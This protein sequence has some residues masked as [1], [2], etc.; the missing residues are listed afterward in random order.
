MEDRGTVT[1]RLVMT[2]IAPVRDRI[3]PARIAGAAGR[4]RVAPSRAPIVVMNAQVPAAARPMVAR[5]EVIG[6]GPRTI[7]RAPVTARRTGAIDPNPEIGR[8]GRDTRQIVRAAGTAPIIGV[9]VRTGV[10][11]P[12]KDRIEPARATDLVIGVTARIRTGRSTARTVQ[13][14]VIA[15][16]TGVIDPSA[17][18]GPSGGIGPIGRSTHRIVRV[19]GTVPVIGVTVRTGATGPHRDRTEPPRATDLVT[20]VTVPIARTGRRTD[21]TAHGAGA[22]R[23][24]GVTVRTA[25]TAR[26]VPIVRSPAPTARSVGN[27]TT[28]R[29]SDPA[30]RAGCPATCRTASRHPRPE[31][32]RTGTPATGR[33]SDRTAITVARDIETRGLGHRAA[34][35]RTAQA[36][37]ESRPAGVRIGRPARI[38][39]TG[40]TTVTRTP[41]SGVNPSADPGSATRTSTSLG[42]R[43]RSGL[44]RPIWNRTSAVTFVD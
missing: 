36:V 2:G 11:G 17:G 7:A 1:G 9:T 35:P 41:G 38:G 31:T 3:P 15:P 24:I 16:S 14:V 22:V 6:R 34:A 4:S 27:A 8:I 29:T 19:A 44:R 40:R 12:G 10:T 20:G 33:A 39:R 32:A 43:C 37:A 23:S 26:E 21:R 42:R 30:G 13:V 28:D 18:I 5:I 25:A